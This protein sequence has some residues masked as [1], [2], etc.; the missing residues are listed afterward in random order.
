MVLKVNLKRVAKVLKL[1]AR[2][3]CRLIPMLEEVTGKDWYR[4]HFCPPPDKKVQ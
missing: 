4:G 1:K 2:N 3:F